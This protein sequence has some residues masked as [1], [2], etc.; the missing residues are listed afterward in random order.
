MSGLF[1]RLR[2]YRSDDAVVVS[3]KHRNVHAKCSSYLVPRSGLEQGRAGV[4][5]MRRGG[6]ADPVRARAFTDEGGGG[7][8]KGEGWAMVEACV[9]GLSSDQR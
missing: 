5:G 1:L 7:G 9:S 2:T 3:G 8:K 4:G 6:L